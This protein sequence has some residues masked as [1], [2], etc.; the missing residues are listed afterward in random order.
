VKTVAVF[1]VFRD[2]DVLAL[3]PYE[4]EGNGFC[5][6]YQH[7][8]QHGLADYDACVNQTRPATPKEYSALKRELEQLGYELIIKK[9]RN[10]KNWTEVQ[11]LNRGVK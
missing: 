5:S 3:F 2:G 8:G 10:Y 1:R 7:V 9:K 4:D 6:S 11:S